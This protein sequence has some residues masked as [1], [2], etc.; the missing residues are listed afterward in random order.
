MSVL[1]T[2]SDAAVGAELQELDFFVGHWHAEGTSFGAERPGT[3][4]RVHGVPWVS[5]E[6]YV[7]LP[8]G[9]FL[10]H[11]WHEHGTEHAFVGTEILG[12]NPPGFQAGLAGRGGYF[13]ELFDNRG[14]HL[15]YT[16][17]KVGNVWTFDEATT[18]A[19][20]TVHD[21]DTVTFNWEWKYNGAVWLPLC[22]RL[23]RRT[24]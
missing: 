1:T 19:I 2:I 4:P 3:D 13:S 5:D 12:F 21:R 24:G 11:R 18:R 20:V 23:A 16:V 6:S 22:D 17:H 14:H 10:M 9:Y 8:G 15:H 7:W